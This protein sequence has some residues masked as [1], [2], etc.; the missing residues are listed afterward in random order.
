[1][2]PSKMQVNKKLLPV[3]GHF[4]FFNAGTAPLVPYLSTYARQLGFSSA[5]VGLIY[6]VLPVFGLIAKPLFGVIADK[7]K[8]QKIIFILFQII[9]IASFWA[10]YAIP[11]DRH[12]KVELD[13]DD[14][15]TRLQSCY[16]SNDLVDTCKVSTI[17][18]VTTT[19]STSC[20]MTCDMS[21]PKMWQTVCEHWHIPQY[22]Y[23]NTNN[24]RF[25]PVLGNITL[26]NDSCVYMSSNTVFMEG[27]K[28]IP[29]C[30][31]GSEYV[32]VNETCSVKCNNT[33]LKDAIGDE[34]LTMT[35]ID[36]HV[37]YRLCT[38]NTQPF[39]E[40][41]NETQES[42]CEASCDLDV[43]TP[44]RLMEICDW[45]KAD[46]SIYCQ[47]K[48]KEGEE[49]PTLLSFTGVIMLS[50]TIADHNC[51]Y[52]RLNHIELPDANGNIVTHYPSC[53]SKG[54]YKLEKDLFQSSCDIRC[55]NSLVNE[56]I[57]AAA[58]SRADNTNQYTTQFAVFFLFMITSWIG[59]AVVVT[60]AD[61]I[62]FDLLGTK[63]SHYG[64][65]RL[66]GS[67]GWGIFSLLTGVLIDLFSDGAYKDYTVAFV[68]M[69]IF[70]L[71]DITV[72]VFLKTD[73]TKMSMNIL[74]DVGSLL[75]SL[76]TF[77][78]LLWTIAV[79]MCTGLVWQFL[80]WLLEDVAKGN[81]D[82]LGSCDGSDYIK[83]LQ[84][85]V[86]AIQTFGGEI[87]FL[88]V[89][90]HILKKL[91]HANI[92]SLVLFAFG[93]RFILYSFLTNAWWALPIEMFQGITFGMFYPT[94]TSYANIVSPPGTETTVQGLVGA[95]F[96]G[97]GTSMGSLIGGYLYNSYGGLITF[98]AFGIGALVCC[99]INW[100]AFTILHRL[101]LTSVPS[102]YSSVVRYEQSNDR[103][104]M[105]EDMNE[106][107]S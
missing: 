57:E 31:L 74:G 47:P 29:S 46:E 75:S 64:R 101:G 25:N 40:I 17:S 71:G 99:I 89:S 88:F 98:R 30:R 37:N 56:I 66:W 94:M 44:W 34:S 86:S 95:V 67:V 2:L 24:I 21:T 5:T 9:I 13:C 68:L 82:N 4:F 85:L 93:V 59:Q 70:M 96:E 73:S 103:E 78:F 105:L 48:T 84:G 79:G 27:A 7:Y 10:I 16:A 53:A 76:P 58:D 72:S 3:K 1:M 83:T 55:E 32:D 8:K 15:I 36:K 100:L 43:N 77:I 107:R 49:F 90:G 11:E 106:R 12:L 81:R 18:N 54:I 65:Q 35:C 22:C 23:S 69:F 42:Y 39:R 20:Q 33:K 62:C 104:Y 52:W 28:Y 38:N 92:M 19:A 91:G 63:V 14:G 60:F 61:A 80:F 51:V 102:G 41:A 45:W 97:V 87:P 6:T 50:Y 26:K